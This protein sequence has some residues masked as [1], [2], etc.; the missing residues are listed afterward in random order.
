MKIYE[1]GPDCPWCEKPTAK[2][3]PAPKKHKYSKLKRPL[4]PFCAGECCAYQQN[5]PRGFI[6]EET[7]ACGW[8][9]PLWDSPFFSQF[10]PAPSWEMVEDLERYTKP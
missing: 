8:T 9:A 3:V 5:A 6:S 10:N 7:M 1:V 4:L 2:V